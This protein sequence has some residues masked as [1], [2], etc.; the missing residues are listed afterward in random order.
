M[1]SHLHC[2]SQCTSLH[3]QYNLAYIGLDKTGHALMTMHNVHPHVH[4]IGWTISMCCATHNVHP[5]VHRSMYDT[6]PHTLALTK[7]AM[8]YLTMYNVYPDVHHI[9][10][11]TSMCCATHNV[12]LSVYCSM[13]NTFLHHTLHMEV[14]CVVLCTSVYIVNGGKCWPWLNKRECHIWNACGTDHS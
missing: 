2:T 6:F 3:V 4:C 9:H 8:L 7:Q 11:S 5:S 12:H 10:W 14:S 13:Y 1:L